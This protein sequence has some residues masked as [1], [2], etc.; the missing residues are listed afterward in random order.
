MKKHIYLAQPCPQQLDNLEKTGIKDQK[1]CTSC[2]LNV[3]DFTSW[4]NDEIVSYLKEHR[5]Q[6][7]C[8]FVQPE[9]LQRLSYFK[10]I[11]LNWQSAI[12]D[13]KGF[14]KYV[15][16]VLII[17][18][19]GLSSCVRKKKHCIG[20]KMMMKEPS[21]QSNK[22]GIIVLLLGLCLFASCVCSHPKK[23]VTNEPTIGMEI[24]RK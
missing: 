13:F 20:G 18:S 4:T 12:L 19:L 9:R 15:A 6:R 24:E 1:H 8:G 10:R 14:K 2:Q 7:T 11:K 21:S 5:T 3:M 17:L 16:L 22:L 23:V